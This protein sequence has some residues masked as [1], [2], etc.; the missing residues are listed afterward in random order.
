VTPAIYAAAA[1]VLVS[2]AIGYGAARM[3]YKPRI[4]AAK[5]DAQLAWAKVELQSNQI[6]AVAAVQ[7]QRDAVTALAVE[8][9]QKTAVAAQRAAKNLQDRPLPPGKNACE[10]ACD[11]LREPLE[12][13]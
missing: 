9:A 6:R 1:G 7:A 12:T 5:A 10:A 3:V 2:V 11:L 13:P 4:A 8:A